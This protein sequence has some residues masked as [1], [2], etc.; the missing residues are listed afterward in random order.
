MAKKRT[1]GTTTESIDWYLISVERLKQIGLVVLILLLG[2]GGYWF[3]QKEKGNPRSNAEAAISEAKQALNALAKSKDLAKQRNQFERANTK[4][5]EAVGLFAQSKFAEAQ[6]AAVESQTISRTA[7]SGGDAEADAQFTNLEGE[8]QFQRAATSDWSRAD[9]RTPLYNGDWVKTG[10]RSSAE[11]MFSNSSLYTIGPNALLEIYAQFNPGSSKKT[12]AVQ[13]RVGSV[14]VATLGDQSTV[15][16][17]GTQVV[18]ESES[19]TQVGVDPAKAT[20]VVTMKG[21]ASVVPASGGTPV[22]LV[23]GHKV[24]ASA[25]GALSAIKKLVLPPALLSPADNQVFQLAPDSRID[26]VWDA[27]Q[28]AANYQL[29]VSR[30]RLFTGLEINSRRLK[31]GA[32]ARVSS[33]G[34]FYWRVASIGPDGEIGPFSQFRRFRVSGGGRGQSAPSADTT[35][36]ALVLKAPFNIGGQFFIIEGTT[37]P[38]STVFINDEEVDVESNGHFKKLISFNKVGRNAVVVKAVDPAGNQTVQSQ[39]VIVEE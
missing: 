19:T 5:Q 11:L 24:T 21:T 7:M 37:E 29:Q 39:T 4:Y 3:Y 28:G 23:S 25:A 12:N 22:K 2:A 34:T 17:P 27:Q 32:A 33:E 38:G 9:L 6:G 36:P 18:V 20:S 14:E 35:P 13:M 10:G 26:F 31:T 16:T 30:S 1:A 15:R 8:V